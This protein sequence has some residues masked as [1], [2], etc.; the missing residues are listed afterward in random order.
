[1]PVPL[2][3]QPDRWEKTQTGLVYGGQP[4]RDTQRMLPGLGRSDLLVPHTAALPWLFFLV[5]EML[6]S[7]ISVSSSVEIESERLFCVMP[8][9]LFSVMLT[10]Y[11]LPRLPDGHPSAARE[12]RLRSLPG[13]LGVL[14]PRALHPAHREGASPALLHDLG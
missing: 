6:C 9:F 5:H 4:V 7:Q 8:F 11:P 1:M 13:V 3:K 14:L 10:P 12:A 2:Q